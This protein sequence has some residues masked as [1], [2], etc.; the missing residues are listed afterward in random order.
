MKKARI[1][2]LMIVILGLL[3]V[4]PGTADVVTLTDGSRLLGQV[5]RLGEGKLVLVTKFAGT[6]EI[7]AAMI[8]SIQTDQPVNVGM[9]S[10]DR[11]VG[12]VEWKHEIDRAVVRT[13]M[14]GV[15]VNVSRITDIWPRDGKSPEVIAMEAQVAKAREEAEAARGKWSATLEAGLLCKEGNTDVFNAR[16]RAELRRQSSD[17]L[18]KFYVSGEYAEENDER[19]TSEVKGGAYYEYLF[20]PR[21]FAYGRMDL[22]YDEFENLDFRFS[23]AVGAGYYWIKKPEHELKTRAGIGYLHESYMDGITR[24][25]AQAEVGLDYRVDIAPWVQFVHGTIW[26]PTFD[27]LQDYRLVSDSALLFPLGGSDVWKLKLG[28]LFEYDSIPNPGYERLDQTYYANILLD[29]K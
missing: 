1:M 17:D 18:L 12:P 24:D 14:G 13:E 10:G 21:W 11:L 19:N 15:P 28:A 22:E 9:D 27:S 3:L 8:A 2:K 29:I 25:A 4:T 5:E 7:D 26:Y 23:S 6:L 16:G 20:T